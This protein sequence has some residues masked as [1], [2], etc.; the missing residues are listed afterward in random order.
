M[1]G[2][3]GDTEVALRGHYTEYSW[4]LIRHFRSP[5]PSLT[6]QEGTLGKFAVGM[7]S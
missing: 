6:F 4:D 3:S 7:Y 1:C 5:L 2:K